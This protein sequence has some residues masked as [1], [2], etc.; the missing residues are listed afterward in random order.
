MAKKYRGLYLYFDQ[1]PLL[2]N[3][4]AGEFKTFALGLLEFAE[5]GTRPPPL[6]S[7]K[8]NNIQESFL[9]DLE[10]SRI[11]SANGKKGAEATN[12]A[13]GAREK[14]ETAV[15]ETTVTAD[16]LNKTDNNKTEHNI[17]TT[18]ES[19]TD[20]SPP[21]EHL[22]GHG[23]YRNVLLTDEEK[24]ALESEHGIPQAYIDHFSNALKTKGYQYAS[25]YS[26][27]L[28]WWEQDK[29]SPRWQSEKQQQDGSFDTDDFFNAAVSRS[30]GE[31]FTPSQYRKKEGET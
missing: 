30:L 3:I 24:A 21:Q 23:T 7:A 22:H 29:S 4:P 31:D 19:V 1:R 14:K 15:G 10:R 18:K 9:L 6:K 2:E 11:N 12:N 26:A 8:A 20:C 28:E 16:G 13:Y 17:A 5:T 27:I 25:H